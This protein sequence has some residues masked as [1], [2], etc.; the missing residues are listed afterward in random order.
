VSRPTTV[1]FWALLFCIAGLLLCLS[2]CGGGSNNS[3]PPGPPPPP[4]P[5]AS[6]LLAI[7]IVPSASSINLGATQ[8]LTATGVFSDGTTQ[9]YTNTVTWSS[10]AANVATVSGSGLAT[11]EGVGS[12]AITATSDKVSGFTLLGVTSGAP[13]GANADFYVATNGNDAWSGTLATPNPGNTDGPFASLDRARQAVRGKPGGV[14]QIRAGNY[15]LSAPVNFS[16]ADSGTASAPIVYENYPGETPVISGGKLI[17]GWQNISG[18]VWAVS[19]NASAYQNFEGLFYRAAGALDAQRRFRPR[20]TQAPANDQCPSYPCSGYLYSSS[21]NPV[22][23]AQQSTNCSAQLSNG[24][25]ECFDQFYFNAGDV[26][27][28][29]HAMTLGDVEVLNF[30]Y[31]TMSRMRLA[32]VDTTNAIAHLTGPTFHDPTT[33]GW[34]PGHRYLIENVRE[35]L[36]QP[37]QW[38]LDRCPDNSQLCTSPQA[39]WTLTYLAQLGEDPATAEIVVPQLSQLI[40]MNGASNLVFQGLTFSHDNWMPP[41]VGLGDV[42]GM[43]DVTAAVSVT[44]SQNVVFNA[45]IFSHTQGWGVEFV[46][47]DSGASGGNQV[48]NSELYDLGAGGIRIGKWPCKSKGPTC[49][50]VDSDSNVPQYNLVENNVIAGGGR[51]QPTGIGT[52]VWV[53]NAHHNV[54]THNDISDYYSGAIGV[55]FTYGITEGTGFAHDNIVSFNRV[56]NL[57]QGVTSDMGGIYLATSATGGNLVLNNVIHDVTHNYQDPDGYGG[58]GVYFDQGTSNAVAHNN[59]VYRLSG[60]AAFNNLSDHITDTYPQNNVFMNNIF[61]LSRRVVIQRGGENPSSFS[62]VHNVAYYDVAKIQGGHWPCY[63]VGGTNQAVPCPSRFFLDS[64]VYWNPSGAAAQFIVTDP[65]STTPAATYTLTEWQG[66]G[67]DVHSVNQDPLFTSPAYPADDFTLQPSSPALNLGFVVFD[68]SQAGRLNP[69]LFPPAV[70][71]A[72]PLQLLDPA[73]GY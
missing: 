42:Q 68:P 51:V 2:G 69:V 65:G 35:A 60:S 9:D 67:E 37:G 53:G 4:Q 50:G 10:S 3:P 17:T 33:S 72:F 16:V 13:G 34:Y 71:I 22:T 52:G 39:T 41:F 23:S 32:L 44:N 1:R 70:P 27:P 43:P 18:N 12:A 8:Q 15:F 36:N 30:E 62:F 64:N 25:W 49:T 58:I 28:S 11:G 63:D 46:G 21:L 45:C 5:G 14:V 66:L 20:T 38:Y 73:N 19:L 24:Q 54:I 31:W 29:Y 57:G 59:L 48:I 47:D 40:V 55:G 26:A 61:A 6:F 56:Y 7:E